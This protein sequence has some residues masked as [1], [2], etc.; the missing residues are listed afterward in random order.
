MSEVIDF[1]YIDHGD[2]HDIDEFI[3]SSDGVVLA[4]HVS[5]PKPFV[6]NTIHPDSSDAEFTLTFIT[7]PI[8]IESIEFRLIVNKGVYRIDVA[9][10]PVIEV[11]NFMF[12][13]RTKSLSATRFYAYDINSNS[14]DFNFFAEGFLEWIR[15]KYPCG[16]VASFPKNYRISPTVA[17]FLEA[18]GTLRR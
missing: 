2:I 15:S 12:D 7:I 3:R 9:R 10:S 5:E 14:I 11:S 4:N 18:G 17:K 6:L 16:T 1:L 13:T 8:I